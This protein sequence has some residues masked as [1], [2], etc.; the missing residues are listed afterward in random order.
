MTVGSKPITGG[1][2]D[3]TLGDAYAIVKLTYIT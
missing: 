1:S 2:G 3:P